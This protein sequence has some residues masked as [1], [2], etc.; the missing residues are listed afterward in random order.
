MMRS[1]VAVASEPAGANAEAG[2]P[3]TQRELLTRADRAALL[4]FMAMMRAAEERGL[5]LYRQGKVPG[6]FYDGCGQEAISVGSSFALKPEDRMCIL[7]RDL[8]AHFVRGVTPD[9]YLA[10][11][12]GRAGGV[13]GGKDGNM[14]FGDPRLGCI[15]MV[16]MLPDMALVACGMALAFKT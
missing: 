3:E 11:Y 15:G 4:R 5:T 9:R 6:S 13:T 1:D 14:H 16:S 7:H 12:M 2:V 8:G 10:N